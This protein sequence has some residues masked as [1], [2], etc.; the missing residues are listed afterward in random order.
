M[1]LFLEVDVVDSKFVHQE[2]A[3]TN[4]RWDNDALQFYIDPLCDARSRTTR[5]YDDNDYAYAVYPNAAGNKSIVWRERSADQ[6]LTLGTAAPK[7]NTVAED[8]PSSFTKTPDGYIYR[9][10]VPAKYLLPVKL[11]KGF[12]IGLGLNVGNADDPSSPLLKR[13]R[14]SVSNAS[15]PGKDCWNKPYLWPAFL[16]W[17]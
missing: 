2:F 7:D 8:I 13:R 4:A 9:V 1:G 12:A 11:E 16:L 6:Q 3:Q 15:E 5:T 10:F 17:D 14:G